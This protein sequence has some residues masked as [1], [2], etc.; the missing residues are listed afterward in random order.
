MHAVRRDIADIGLADRIFAPHYARPQI[1][2]CL[3]ASVMIR[4]APDAAAGAVSQLLH[5]ERFAV[6]DV[7]AGWAWGYSVHDNYVGY[8]P[9]ETLGE[10]AVPT[11]VVVAATALVFAAP[12]IKAPVRSCW[13][14]G[15]RFVGG[16]EGS[17]VATEAGYVHRRHVRTVN[18]AEPDPVAIAERLLGTPYLWGGRGGGGVDCSGLVQLALGLARIP[19]PRDSDQQ[20]AALGREIPADE[21]LRRGDILFFPG[22]VGFMM[23]EDRLIHANAHWMAVTIEPLAEVIARLASEHDQPVLARRRIEP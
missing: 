9:Q 20:R 21:P 1:C 17:F 6:V 16:D 15:A 14:L 5:G 19:S 11:H 12:D 22:H 2:G 4:A 8:V 23:D 13:P 18:E 7:G 3:S 10:P